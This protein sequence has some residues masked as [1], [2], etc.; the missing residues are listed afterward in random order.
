[1]ALRSPLRFAPAEV[2]VEKRADGTLVLRSP[3]ALH[4][5]ERSVGVWLL[6]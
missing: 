3:R 1:M 4:D 5:Y 2:R 6:R